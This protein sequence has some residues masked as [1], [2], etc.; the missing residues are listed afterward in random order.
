MYV[1]QQHT[2][3]LLYVAKILF[4]ILHALVLRTCMSD[5]QKKTKKILFAVELMLLYTESVKTERERE[6]E[7]DKNNKRMF[8]QNQLPSRYSK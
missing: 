1:R 5:Q 7:R 6:R 4:D 2:G 3:V 8:G